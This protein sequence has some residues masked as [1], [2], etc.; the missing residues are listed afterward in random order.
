[1]N[2]NAIVFP[3]YSKTHTYTHVYSLQLTGQTRNHLTKFHFR[4]Q[5]FHLWIFSCDF[6]NISCLDFV[7]IFN[8][9]FHRTLSLVAHQGCLHVYIH[10][11]HNKNVQVIYFLALRIAKHLKY[12]IQF[13]SIIKKQIQRAYF[14]LRFLVLW[15]FSSFSRAKNVMKV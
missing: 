7:F 4:P 8:L 3:K 9:L 11:C 10:K 5:L 2:L 1:M 6:H 12:E 15:V 14:S 13:N